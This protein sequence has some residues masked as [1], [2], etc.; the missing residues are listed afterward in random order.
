MMNGGCWESG[1][2]EDVVDYQLVVG[3][4]GWVVGVIVEGGCDLG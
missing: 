1:E 4:S 2:L 3:G